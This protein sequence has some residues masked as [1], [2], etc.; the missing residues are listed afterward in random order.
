MPPPPENEEQQ[1]SIVRLE[2]IHKTYLLG[3]EGVPAL[4]GVSALVE[5]GEFLMIC[6]TSGGGKTTILN[7]VGT[8]DKP[9]KGYLTLCG[10]SVTPRTSD[11]DLASIRRTKMGFVFQTFNLLSTMTAVEN[12]ELPLILN[13][14]PITKRR[15]RAKE[16]LQKVQMGERLDHFPNML[17]GGEQ[18][19]V[20]IARALANKPDLLLLDEPT[21]DLDTKNTE[22]VMRMLLDLNKQEGITMI[23]VTHDMNLTQFAHRIIRVRDGKIVG[24]EHP[25]RGAREEAIRGLTESLASHSPWA[26]Q[27][28]QEE[29]TTEYYQADASP[30]VPREQITPQRTQLRFP[31]DYRPYQFA[32]PDD[33]IHGF[34]L[35]EARLRRFEDWWTHYTT[36]RQHEISLQA[37]QPQTPTG[38]QDTPRSATAVPFSRAV[39]ASKRMHGSSQSSLVPVLA[40]LSLKKA[41]AQPPPGEFESDAKAGLQDN[42]AG[43]QS[44]SGR[45]SSPHSQIIVPPQGY[46][47]LE[48]PSINA[49]NASPLLGHSSPRFT[50]EHPHQPHPV[51]VH[52]TPPTS[53]L[54]ETDIGPSSPRLQ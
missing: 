14:Y 53:V 32:H 3:I 6:G 11:D 34:H 42:G 16:L 1:E 35:D 37:L 23:M 48:S 46:Q 2:N 12:V 15:A 33:Q 43:L 26:L 36:Q 18:Q 8:I 17:S 19:R 5:K 38:G 29:E 20:T 4:R 25:D 44:S 30:S 13:G 9:T 50:L 21:G 52:T 49:D 51:A 40:D 22:I 54:A 24:Q 45:A 39:E 28:A 27:P 41:E 7:I 10:L 31:A 47:A